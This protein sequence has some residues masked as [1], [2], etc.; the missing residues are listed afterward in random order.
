MT[1]KTLR[2]ICPLCSKEGYDGDISEFRIYGLTITEIK[3]RLDF[4]IE[5]GY[6][7]NERN[8]Q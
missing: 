3:E 4:A 7:K 1:F 8:N 2:V 5:R 6:Q